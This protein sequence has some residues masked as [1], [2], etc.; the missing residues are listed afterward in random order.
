MGGHLETGRPEIL[1]AHTLT[2]Q[3]RLT[4]PM[5][6]D[7]AT[8]KYVTVSWQD[9]FDEIGRHL[10]TVRPEEAEFYTSGRA[11]LETAYMYQLFARVY[12]S[13]NMPD[14][15]NMGHES[16]SVGL[17]ESIGASVGTTILSDFENTDCIFYVAQNVGTSSPR[18]LIFTEIIRY[19][20]FVRNAIARM[21]PCG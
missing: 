12:G 7:A 19:V 1:C 20:S 3:G 13:N 2:E 9:A 4:H 21:Y 11:W 15:S 10:Q 8:D 14:C 18:C 17:P 5:R 6:W 16:S